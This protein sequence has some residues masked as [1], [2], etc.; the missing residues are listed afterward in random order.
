MVKYGYPSAIDMYRAYSHV[1]PFLS[2]TSISQDTLQSKDYSLSLYCMHFDIHLKA[3]PT[4][5]LL[6]SCYIVYNPTLLTLNDSF[7]YQMHHSNVSSSDIYYFFR[8]DCL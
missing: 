3:P 5:D 8:K 1:L 6:A 4:F 7:V 2:D